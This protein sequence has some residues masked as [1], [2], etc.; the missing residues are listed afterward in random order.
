MNV[1]APWIRRP[2]ATTLIAIGILLVGILAYLRLP[3][4][5]LPSVDRPTISVWAGL[6]G[7]SADTIASAVAQPLERQ[8]GTIPGVAE[9]SSFSA[10]GGTQ[11]T[12]QFALDKNIDAA[13]AALQAAI[14]AAGP[15]LPKDMPEPPGHWKVNPSGWSVITLALTSDV[16]DPSDVY[17]IADTVVAEQISQVPGVAQLWIS[18]A[19]RGAVRIRVD[20]GRIAAMHVSLEQVRAAVRGATVN[21]PKGRINLDGQTWSIAVNDQLYKAPEYRDIVVSWRNSAPVL[22]RD[23]AEVTKRGASPEYFCGHLHQ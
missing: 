15:N 18:G 3:I 10:T 9:M 16:L 13:D 23:I 12:V 6:P 11:L 19:E 14:N 20:P 21:L 4:A 5:A 22:L 1:S 17:D 7:A 8:I 2:V